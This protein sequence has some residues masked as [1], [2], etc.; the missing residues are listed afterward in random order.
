MDIF[1][2]AGAFTHARAA[3]AAGLYPYF[4]VFDG[5]DAT[6]ARLPSGQ[7]VVMC[8]SNNYLG[9]TSDRRVHAAAKLAIDEYGTSRTGSRLLNG[10]TPL[11]EELEA[12][13]ADFLGMP[14][15]LVFPT[16][17]QAN[18]GVVAGLLSRHD[19][20]LIDREAHASV[21]DACSMGPAKVRR[22]AHNDL[23]DLRRRLATCPAD[24]GKL[25]VVDGVYSMGGDLPPLPEV[26]ELCRRYGARLLVDDAHGVGVL[27]QGR[28]TCAH[29]GLTDQ[30]DLV[31]ITF[32]KALASVGGAVLGSEDVIEY[33]RHHARSLIF[34]AA[35]PPASL[36]AVLAAIRLV[37]AE[38]WR[39]ELALDN[40]RYVRRGLVELGYA[41]YPTE[42]PIICVPTHDLSGTLLAWRGLLD[43]GVYV[44]AVLPPAASPRLRLS[45]GAAHTTE[46]L[47]RTVAA[48]GK[49]RD[50]LPEDL[51]EPV[52]DELEPA[53]AA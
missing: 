48:F 27:A 22:F 10:N 24:A 30:V 16:G 32:S 12:E 19:V 50:L 39:C 3:R 6:I 2:R 9:L 47:D 37:R 17:Y 31:S 1:E 25:V 23:D 29:F 43:H 13:L 51:S 40:A 49:V 20:V 38:P 36:A 26:V 18:L 11:H 28:G 8:G 34:S 21:Y 35:A 53:L 52:P 7:E 44:N 46:Q 42:T 14:A 45:V 15:A 4:T 5:P 33:L 41:P